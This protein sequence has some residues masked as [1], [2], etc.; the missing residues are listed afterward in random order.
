M[1]EHLAGHNPN[2]YR[3][4]KIGFVLGPLLGLILFFLPVPESMSPEAWKV[5]ALAAWVAIWWGTEAIPIPATSLIPIVFL[6]LLGISTLSEASNPYAS[7]IIYLLLGGFIIA[8]SMQ[9]WNLHRRIALMILVRFGGKLE[10]IVLGFMVSTALLSMWVSNTATTLM[11]VPIALSVAQ[12]IT[13]NWKDNGQFTIA[14]LIG[15]AYAASIGGMATIVGTPPNA[16]V[17]AYL[18]ETRN[19]Q[20]GFLQW[21]A[22]G[23]PVTLV[24]LPAAWFVLV[25]WVYKMPEVAEEKGRVVIEEEIRSLGPVST[26]ERRTFITFLIVALLWMFRPLLDNWEPLVN[27]SDTII[28]I[29]GAI[30]MFIIPAGSKDEPDQFLL[31]WEWAVRIPWGVVLLFGGGPSLAAAVQATGLSIWLGES[32]VA[33]TTLHLFILMLALVAM[34]VFLTEL[35]SNTATTAALLPILGALAIVGDFDPIL[36]A[37]PAAIAASCAF[38]LPVATAPNAIIF[39]GGKVTIPDMM[40]TGIRLNLLGIIIVSV[41]CYLL[42]PV[43]FGA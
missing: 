14:L 32:F 37:A 34:V 8:M 36:L 11:M 20:I 29:G 31:N 30:A 41:L 16:L 39:A 33:L 27:L 25:K 9:R 6:P 35:T 17:V 19:I 38:M 23:L 15:I 40:K 5:V 10:N 21:M 2:R 22:F 3:Y 18:L 24:L 42:V 12:T 13:N 7:P 4:Q 26:P 1:S 43:I 28:A